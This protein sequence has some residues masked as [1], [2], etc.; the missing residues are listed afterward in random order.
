VIV[1]LLTTHI[2]YTSGDRHTTIGG[3]PLLHPLYVAYYIN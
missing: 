3:I 2:A 1:D